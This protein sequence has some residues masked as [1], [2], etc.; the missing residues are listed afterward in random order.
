M[1]MAGIVVWCILMGACV[2]FVNGLG[3][4]A[5]T[6]SQPGAP[7]VTSALQNTS[8]KI[9]ASGLPYNCTGNTNSPGGS[10]TTVQTFGNFIWSFVQALP[11]IAQGALTPGSIANSWFGGIGAVVNVVM[12]I[13]L[14]LWGWS[15]VG[16]RDPQ[17]K[18][19]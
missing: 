12:L 17:F 10:P 2:T 1:N 6:L 14:S 18:P 7:S 4:F 8:C 11:T 19:E 15:V 3:L 13:L 9:S 16:N 5:A